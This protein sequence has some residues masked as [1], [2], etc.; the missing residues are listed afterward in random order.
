M[1][2]EKRAEFE[3]FHRPKTN[4]LMSTEAA[5]FCFRGLSFKS[6]KFFHVIERQGNKSWDRFAG[7]ASVCEGHFNWPGPIYRQ[8]PS[9]ITF[10]GM[11]CRGVSGQDLLVWYVLFLLYG[12]AVTSWCH[13][14]LK[15][16]VLCRHYS[17]FLFQIL[18]VSPMGNSKVSHNNYSL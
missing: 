16:S 5:K 6:L 8:V 18:I 9:H 11:R 14:W 1:K 17:Y 3:A 15:K 13:V 10:L 4:T 7:K 12:R 2:Q